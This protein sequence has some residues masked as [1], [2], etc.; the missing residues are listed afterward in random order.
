V[1]GAKETR[2]EWVNE[3]GAKQDK[4]V[5]E[6]DR[7]G[8]ES[9]GC[10]VLPETHTHADTQ[11]HSASQHLS[12]SFFAV[13]ALAFARMSLLA[14]FSGRQTRER[15]IERRARVAQQFSGRRLHHLDFRPNRDQMRG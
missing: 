14:S 6:T 12:I 7:R 11:A 15:A 8:R 13:A 2:G 9:R 3:V 1:G 10:A 5:T 4:T